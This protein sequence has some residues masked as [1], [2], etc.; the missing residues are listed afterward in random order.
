[1]NNTTILLHAE[2][3][4]LEGTIMDLDH[5]TNA[6]RQEVIIRMSRKASN[7]M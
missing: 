6:F 7:N 5:T 3:T 1:M 4:F 2:A